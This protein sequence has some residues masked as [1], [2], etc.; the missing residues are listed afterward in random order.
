MP[1]AGALAMP[2]SCPVPEGFATT[3]P[4]FATMIPQ[5]RQQRTALAGA[6]L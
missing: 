4:P 3:E 2:R 1:L 6:S 5:R